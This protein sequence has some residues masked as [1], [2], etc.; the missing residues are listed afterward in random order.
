MPRHRSAI[1]L[2]LV[3]A[4]AC[5]P[6]PTV[7]GG[8]EDTATPDSPFMAAATGGEMMVFPPASHAG[9]RRTLPRA[10]AEDETTDEAPTD[11]QWPQLGDDRH[12]EIAGQ[13]LRIH[14]NRSIA[15]PPADPAPLTLTP[16]VDGE[17]SWPSP[18]VLAFRATAPFD[19][20]TEYTVALGE[21]HDQ[22][23]ARVAEGWTG[24]FIAQPRVSVGGK[25]IS[26]LP[27][28]GTPRPVAVRPEYVSKV[29]RDIAPKILFDQPVTL[30][31]VAGMLHGEV[32]GV[33]RDLTLSHA[34]ED[35][36]EGTPV[37]RRHVVVATPASRPEPGQRVEL[38]VDRPD[39]AMFEEHVYEVA[40]PLEFETVDCQSDYYDQEDRCTWKDG[41][42]E[43]TGNRFSVEFNNPIAT[44]DAQLAKKIQVTPKVKNL[45]IRA[46]RWR[47]NGVV[48]ISGEFRSSTHYTVKVGRV[49][50]RYGSRLSTPL[51]LA[52]DV[53]PQSASV[54]MPEGQ[55]VL[56]EASSR[57]FTLTTRNVNEA[58]VDLW[59][60]EPRA[61][62]WEDAR[63][64]LG[65]RERPSRSPDL[66]IPVRP[67]ARRDQSVETTVDL[68]AT[69][70]PG[71]T[72]LAR[73]ELETPA[74]GAKP[75]AY[76]EWAMAARPPTALLTPHD[77]QSLAVHVHAGRDETLVHV[78]RL[79]D[80]T[81]VAG[82]HL[83]VDGT[84]VSGVKTG[85]DGMAV[86]P[87]S[88]DDGPGRQR[89]HV[90]EV[91]ADHA[92]ATVALGGGT[93]DEGDL[94]PELSG[95]QAPL[96]DI[97]ALVL[98]DRGVYRPGATVHLKGMVQFRE[99]GKLR[100]APTMPVGLRIHAP[101]GQ[102]V[103]TEDGV[104]SDLGSFA[105]SF[106]VPDSAEIGRYRVELVAPLRDDAVLARYGLQIAEFEPPRFTVDV[107]AQVDTKTDKGGQTLRADVHGRYLFGA[108]MEDAPVAW[109]LRRADAPFP[110]GPLTA[111]GLHFRRVRSWWSEDKGEAWMRVG[112]GTLA[113]DGHLRVSPAVEL[114]ADRGPQRFTLEAEV[115]DQSHRAI[116]GR[117]SVVLHA[118]DRYAGLRLPD[119]WLDVGKALA[120]EAGV[121]D[122]SGAT[123][124]D[125]S[126]E[127]RLERLTWRR[128]RRPGPGGFAEQQWHEVAEPTGRCT[129]T[130]TD[131]S[132]CRLV[133]RRSGSYRVS[134]FIDGRRGGSL[135]AW[136]WGSAW[137]SDGSASQPSPGRR[138]E[139]VADRERYA[140][141][142]TAELMVRNPFPEATAI[143]TVE[144]G[145]I[146]HHRTIHVTE[147][148]ARF[149]VPLTAEHAPHAH[150]TITLLPRGAKGDAR[151]D[152][153][154]GAVRLPVSLEDTRLDVTV[155]SDRDRYEPG[156]SVDVVV[157]VSRGGVAVPNAEVA[158]A[159]VDEGVL[160]LTNFHAADPVPLL[161][162]G[163]G[164]EL[165]V[166]D[167]RR[168]LAEQLRRSHVAGDGSGA[169]S[170]SLVSTRKNF[171]KTALW[172]PSLRTDA[173]GRAHVHFTLPDNLT[174]FRMM[175]VVI[176]ADGRGGV[177]EDDFEVQMPLMAVPAVPRFAAIGDRFEAAVL[178][179][180]N[181][182]H[183]EQVTVTLGAQSQPVT[184][185]AGGRA[186]VAFEQTPT[187]AT[188]LS[189]E[190]SVADAS[191]T[192]RDRVEATVPVQAPG[193]DE[194]PVIH[195]RFLGRQ[196]VALE[197]PPEVFVD[198]GGEDF[199]TV[200][201]GENLWPELGSR[202]E[203][204]I[205]YPHGCVE[206]TTSSTLP[207]LAA[208]EILPRMGLTRYDDEQL[209][210]MIRAGV[211]RLSTM[212]TSEGG[213]A[214]W[215]GGTDPNP[216]GTA[217][218]T[219]A[220]ARAQRLGIE[221]PEGMID[222]MREYLVRMVEARRPPHGYGVEVRASV[223]LALAELE[224]L[225]PSIA[226][227]LHDT[228]PE[229]GVFGRA[230][231]AL[232]LSS[233]P[234]QD[235][236]VH[237]LLDG[238]ETAFDEQGALLEPRK[239]D[240]G[241]YGSDQR[242]IA[243]SALA[244]HRLRPHSAVLPRLVGNLLGR[245]QGYTTQGTAYGLLA[246]SE[247]VSAAE[248][249]A[250]RQRALLDDV[251]LMP[252]LAE[253]VN[254]GPSVRRYRIPLS[255][256]R[257]RRAILTMESESTE[258]QAF[259]VSA[260]WRRPTADAH[261]P[262]ATTTEHG[263]DLYRVITDAKGRRVDFDAITPGQV[264]RV[265]LLA[266]MP[267][268]LAYERRGYLAITDRLP[269]G[270]EAMQ[271]DLWTVSEVPALDDEHPLYDHLRW[272]SSS[273]SH[274]E[275]RDDRAH[276]YFDRFWGQ[277]VHATYLM[278]ATTPG[279]FEA[280][281]AMAELMYEPD[282][283]GYSKA[284]TFTVVP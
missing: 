175:A 198:A 170:H 70:S 235:D 21:L 238:I 179:H 223:A 106:P 177:H 241:Y 44:P 269:A 156:E 192:V 36:F 254:L 3:Q 13:T 231:L 168:L 239:D 197:I 45:R 278:R 71:K 51:R 28:A 250:A 265:V 85:A 116:A 55:Q 194:R 64:Q 210:P 57:R 135:R 4:L 107:E 63:R 66:S 12:F 212:R 59:E 155:A 158:L 2:L 35:R 122:Q 213:L 6:V 232:A 15:P 48:W 103:F 202:L 163:Q 176:D 252:V 255:E 62:A 162:P 99:H 75:P 11:V 188:P 31:Q 234:E 277:W 220:I 83:L 180:N 186:R 114:P 263:P 19:P 251:D 17:I 172:K 144:Q 7:A 150:A 185:A 276:F 257:G 125:A 253:S 152:W 184:I 37:D 61:A 154:L 14:F 40:E 52:V 216:F 247:R 166:D 233:L 167:S 178:V 73:L 101:T 93:L 38:R 118:A 34:K 9:P 267:Q 200:T 131:T 237:A 226:D 205:D 161:Y 16:A 86:L 204:L 91:E 137:G 283:A 199:V 22:E 5:Q 67:R 256:L 68:L 39:G 58:R 92:R 139:I 124:P 196:Q 201:V 149:R 182:D 249:S 90:L 82:A 244:L 134:A 94:A 208:R 145:E 128:V 10:I 133:P 187:R 69:L 127:I 141:G 121:I 218:A 142:D 110:R 165:W 224:A 225:P 260:R 33:A 193:V 173:E 76:P 24:T 96:D 228:V 138:I 29:G 181:Q 130:G 95:G 236:R 65:G 211:E 41:T 20:Q 183:E 281:P 8:G 264:L 18:W 282:S 157:D 25:I 164:L 108:A 262:A 190:F 1:A 206:Q 245:S 89:H 126:F 169:G 88:L 148:A 266:R 258:S 146:L 23:G 132:G 27:E 230:T 268:D 84:R 80:G 105:T 214:Y 191:G 129:V 284:R 109:T 159:V 78:A 280:P 248:G 60:I 87:R 117:A 240:F 56:D 259:V 42:L 26:Y 261:S 136:A 227:A 140:P 273:T 221:A 151:V 272:T 243:Q 147:S 112:E 47:S 98:S 72:Y 143:L 97:R 104:T 189:L 77:D 207:L 229:Q 123:V 46:D 49:R 115:T 160:R 275:L 171:V 203:Y 195:G 209:R 215:P 50:D 270:F 54:S 279:R 113:A 79:H 242:T 111:K 32:D 102:E 274:M 222:G 120:L 74:F 217:Y 271:P 119:R 81:P 43:L 246:L 53:A 100:A 153:K 174:R 30:A 219:L